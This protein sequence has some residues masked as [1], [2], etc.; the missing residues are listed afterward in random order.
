MRTTIF[1][2]SIS[3]LFLAA[4]SFAQSVEVSIED[5]FERRSTDPFLSNLVLKLYVGG[6]DEVAPGRKIKVSEAYAI[7]ERGDTLQFMNSRWELFSISTNCTVGMQLPSRQ[8]KK[9]P[10][11][12]G[13]VKIFT[14]IDENRS[15]LRIK[16]FRSPSDRNLLAGLTE[17][18]KMV[19]V[20]SVDYNIVFPEFRK[21]YRQQLLDQYPDLTEVAIQEAMSFVDR[22][23]ATAKEISEQENVINLGFDDP[24]GDIYEVNIYDQDGNEQIKAGSEIRFPMNER[25]ADLLQLQE[26]NFTHLKL[27]SFPLDSIPNKDWEVEIVYFNEQFVKEYTFELRNIT[28]P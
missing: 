10:L 19:I 21:V 17:Q 14:P 24:H 1:F 28:L 4:D 6:F 13:K 8:V 3:L 22:I 20:D 2:L 15:G 11:I 12:R 23:E 5:L 26:Q 25:L 18:L 9:L 7:D 16:P 27:N